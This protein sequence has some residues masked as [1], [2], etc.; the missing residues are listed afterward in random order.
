MKIF[1]DAFLSLMNRNIYQNRLDLTKKRSIYE[2]NLRK[3]FV[4]A[5][6]R[7]EK[8]K[9]NKRAEKKQKQYLVNLK[10]I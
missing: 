7:S 6:V 1:A 8:V 9:R 3:T 10:K 2:R 4:S 5:A